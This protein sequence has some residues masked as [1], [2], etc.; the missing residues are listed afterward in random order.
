[1]CGT[2]W[3][4][5]ALTTSW[6]PFLTA[7]MRGVTPSWSLGEQGNDDEVHVRRD[8]EYDKRDVGQ[9]KIEKGT[10]L[11]LR[12]LGAKRGEEVGSPC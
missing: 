4:K 2:P 3:P 10:H 1:M 8:G 5:S 12:C 9:K 7:A 11:F 6:W